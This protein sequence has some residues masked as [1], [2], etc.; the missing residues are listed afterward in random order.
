MDVQCSE[1]GGDET[2]VTVRAVTFHRVNIISTSDYKH[3]S[4]SVQTLVR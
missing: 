2:I 1:H 4:L 3:L